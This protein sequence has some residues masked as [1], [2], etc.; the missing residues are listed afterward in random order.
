LVNL[1][2]QDP[3]FVPPPPRPSLSDLVNLVVQEPKCFPPLAPAGHIWSTWSNRIQ[4]LSPLAQTGHIWSTWLDRKPN[5]SSL[6]PACYIWSTWSNRIQN[7]FPLAPAG[8][9]WLTWTN[10]IPNSSLLGLAP[11]ETKFWP[12]TEEKSKKKAKDKKSGDPL[13]DETSAPVDQ[14]R[15]SRTCYSRNLSKFSSR[16]SIVKLNFG[17]SIRLLLTRQPKFTNFT[18]FL[19]K[20]YN[21]FFLAQT[22]ACQLIWQY[23]PDNFRAI[24]QFY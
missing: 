20:N 10:R 11:A 13:C 12:S 15:R 7:L 23:I 5:W 21:T 17:N 9:I 24:H 14:T 3:I 18:K 8:H 19:I 16:K 4:N 22:F 2:K 1:F 6:A